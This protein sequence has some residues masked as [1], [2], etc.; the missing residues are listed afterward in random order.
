MRRNFSVDEQR[1]LDIIREELD[2]EY[3]GD[4]YVREAKNSFTGEKCG[5]TLVLCLNNLDKP[6]FINYI[7]DD[8]ETFFKLVRKQIHEDGIPS[9]VR[10][11]HANYMNTEKDC[12]EI[13]R[14]RCGQ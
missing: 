2:C 14:N 5:W 9:H 8:K 10:Y 11:Y 7:G 3:I 6:M 4:L 1:C 12:K 13:R